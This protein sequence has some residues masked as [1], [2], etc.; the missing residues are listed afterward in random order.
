VA[1]W[2]IKDTSWANSV[3][4]RAQEF[5]SVNMHADARSIALVNTLFCSGG[6]VGDVRLLSPETV[7]LS[8]SE[9]VIARDEFL[10]ATYSFSK[11]GFSRLEDMQT[12]VVPP[13][14]RQIYDGFWGW[15]GLGGSWSLWDPHRRVSFAYMMNAKTF[16][17]LGGPRGDRIMRAVQEVLMQEEVPFSPL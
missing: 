8:F 6:V 4:G 5:P 9:P 16:Q 7:A 15:G 11:G 12:I 3:A 2:L 17:N 13:D 14:F 1:E 10:N